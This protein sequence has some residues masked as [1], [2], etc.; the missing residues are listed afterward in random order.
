[1]AKGKDDV[2]SQRRTSSE[3]SFREQT[4]TYGK[5][6]PKETR[7]KGGAGLE[8]TCSCVKTHTRV[9]PP[10]KG[11]KRERQKGGRGGFAQGGIERVEKH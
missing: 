2:R 5:R 4:E 6:G 8:S 10:G 3:E 1:M 11:S 7:W 9:S